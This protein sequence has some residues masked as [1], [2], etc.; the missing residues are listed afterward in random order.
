MKTEKSEIEIVI[1]EIEDYLDSCKSAPLS[2][3]K[4]IVN[5]DDID[6]LIEELKTKTPK[7]RRA[8]W[9]PCSFPSKRCMG[10]FFRI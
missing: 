1:E 9:K 5:R 6:S 10:S 4:I 2:Q 8:I 3:T 7:G